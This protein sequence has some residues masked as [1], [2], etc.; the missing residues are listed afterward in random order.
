MTTVSPWV[1]TLE[2]LAPYR[3]PAFK[4]AEGDPAPLPHLCTASD[5]KNGGLDITLE[6]Y[7]LTPEMRR[8]NLEP[9]RLSRSTT[10][11]L[12][13]TV[14][15]M[16]THH[17]S[18]GC[19][20]ETGDLIGTGTVSGTDK[21]SWGSLLE[22]TARGSVPLELPNGE[23][24]CFLEDGDEVSFRGVCERKNHPRIGFGE[25]RAVILATVES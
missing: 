19:N 25:C 4:R 17:A 21:S 11:D 3:T 6:A 24:R 22:L 5:I 1:V 23:K 9:S 14:G 10:A 16:V 8:D 18:N 20:L 13:W 7:L 15:Q 12:Y 2:A